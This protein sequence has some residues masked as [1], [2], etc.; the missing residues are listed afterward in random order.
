MSGE[1]Q[2]GSMLAIP[3]GLGAVRL[4]SDASRDIRHVLGMQGCVP[5][6]WTMVEGPNDIRHVQGHA[7]WYVWGYAI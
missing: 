6:W 2:L 4:V 3:D 7:I 1:L 5:G